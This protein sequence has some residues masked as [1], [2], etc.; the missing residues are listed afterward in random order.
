VPGGKVCTGP[1]EGHLMYFMAKAHGPA[2]PRAA[3]VGP[4]CAVTE[5]LRNPVREAKAMRLVG[6]GDEPSMCASWKDFW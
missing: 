6:V 5:L 4:R 3:L 1:V 2:W